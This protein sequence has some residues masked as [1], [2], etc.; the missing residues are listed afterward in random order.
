MWISGEEVF[1]QKKKRGQST[2][3]GPDHYVH[4]CAAELGKSTVLGWGQE[5]QSAMPSHLTCFRRLTLVTVLMVKRVRE[6]TFIKTLFCPLSFLLYFHYSS[7]SRT[8]Q[9]ILWSL[10]YPL[11]S[12]SL[13]R[14]INVL[15]V[16]TGYPLI[17]WCLSIH[18]FIPQI[19]IEHILNVNYYSW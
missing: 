4:R 5:V 18:W 2:H 7:E 13:F 12:P 1:R 17:L 14:F 19:C 9:E 11:F 10:S 16:L 6:A 15:P 3:A 8:A